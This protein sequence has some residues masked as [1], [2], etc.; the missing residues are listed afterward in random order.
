MQVEK[1]DLELLLSQL[2]DQINSP[3]LNES[4]LLRLVTELDTLLLIDSE[5]LNLNEVSNLR[6]AYDTYLIWASQFI[7]HCNEEKKR[8]SNELVL[9]SRR[10][11]AKK[12]YQR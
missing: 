9:L 10:K 4:E 5:Q 11:N 7:T 6:L 12:H 2:E 8:I 3:E 1:D